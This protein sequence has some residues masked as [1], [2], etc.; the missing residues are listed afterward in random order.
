MIAIAGTVVAGLLL[1]ISVADPDRFRGIA[2]GRGRDYRAG[3]AVSSTVSRRTTND[4]RQYVGL[5]RCGV[6]KCGA[7]KGSQG[8]SHE[9]DRSE[10]A[11]A[12]KTRRLRGLLKLQEDKTEQVAVGRLISSTASSTR[13]IATLSIGSNYAVQRAQPVRGTVGPDRARHRNRPD[14]RAHIAH[15]RCRKSGPCHAR[16]RRAAGLF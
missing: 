11:C 12:S 3:R 6:K 2:C 5:F 9:V 1:V 15:H 14:H 16:Q 8:E 4:R 10:G 7:D 13:R